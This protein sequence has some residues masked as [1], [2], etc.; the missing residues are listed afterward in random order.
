MK[1]NKGMYGLPHAG[2]L[3][4][5]LLT[6]HLAKYGYYQAVHTPELWKHTWCTIQFVL[7]K[8]DFGIKYMDKRM[9]CT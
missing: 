6:H 3:A 8:D 5:K 9:Q 2:L 4:K 1:L 7:V